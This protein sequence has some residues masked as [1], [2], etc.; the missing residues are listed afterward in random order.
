MRVQQGRAQGQAPTPREH[1]RAPRAPALR[2]R[3]RRPRPSSAP[4]RG[5]TCTSQARVRR[6]PPAAARTAG[7]SQHVASLQVPLVHV[8]LAASALRLPAAQL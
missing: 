4:S 6:H 7:A 5:A 3:A 8:R 2:Q 1:G